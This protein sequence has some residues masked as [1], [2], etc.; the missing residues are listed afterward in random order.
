MGVIQTIISEHF[1]VD[2]TNEKSLR[3]FFTV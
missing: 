3:F 2:I 1:I